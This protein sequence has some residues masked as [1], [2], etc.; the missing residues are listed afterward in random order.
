MH[1]GLR[2]DRC[3]NEFDTGR[4]SLFSS[5]DLRGRSMHLLL[6]V[7]VR[8]RDRWGEWKTDLELFSCSSTFFM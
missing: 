7:V 8:D 1:L 3:V 6:P 2:I 5:L 4:R